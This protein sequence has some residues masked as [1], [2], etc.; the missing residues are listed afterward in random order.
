MFSFLSSKSIKTAQIFQCKLCWKITIGVFFAILVVEAAILFFSVDNY[1]RDRLAELER[2]ALVVMRAIVRVA[3]D[4]GTLKTSLPIVG[5]KLRDNSV[6]VGSRVFDVRGKEIGSFGNVP[7]DFVKGFETS[8]VTLRSFA[9]DETYMDIVW[10][11]S[12]FKGEYI[13]S[14]RIDSSEIAAQVMAFIWRIAGLVL[15]ISVF[16]TVVTMFV[17]NSL[18]LSPIRRLRRQLL[19]ASE[20]PNNPFRHVTDDH[21]NDEWGDV[22]HALNHMFRQSGLNLDKIKKQ[23]AELIEHRDRLE[24]MVAQRTEKLEKAREQAEM[25]SRAKSA[26]LSNMSHELRTPLNAMIGFSDLQKQEAHGPLGHDSYLEYAEEI[27]VSSKN[28]LHLIN[29]L[30]D[31]TKLESAEFE[32]SVSDFDIGQ[33]LNSSVR[34]FVEEARTKNIDMTLIDP[35]HA[36]IISGDEKRLKQAFDNILSNAIKFSRSGDDVS[37][38]ICED[39]EHNLRIDVKDTG[40]GLNQDD[41]SKFLEQFGQAESAYSRGYDGIGLG[42]TLTKSIMRLHGGKINLES[43]P[44]EGTVASLIIPKSRVMALSS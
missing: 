6:L 23:E 11:T 28:L 44:G 31:V 14:V 41:M 10:N 17:M 39:S 32:L 16:V 20:D 42:L 8:E 21:T 38:S 2:E 40:V 12:R 4:Q 15:L 37:V 19:Q 35:N 1:K 34:K 3:D 24:Q 18:L 27:N 30:L 26:F 33:A 25:A 5:P 13:V 36:Y 22:I 7:S 43:E 29:T 9:T